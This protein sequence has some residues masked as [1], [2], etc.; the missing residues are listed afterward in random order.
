MPNIIYTKI[1]EISK[2]DSEN[3]CL[4]N[5]MEKFPRDQILQKDEFSKCMNTVLK[6][7]T[8]NKY[9]YEK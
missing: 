3:Q 4:K 2:P 6:R 8:V 7:C 5:A 1:C 9:K